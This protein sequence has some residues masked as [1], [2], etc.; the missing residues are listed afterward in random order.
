[1]NT[2]APNDATGSPAPQQ[3]WPRLGSYE[4]MGV[5]TCTEGGPK[6]WVRDLRGN[7]GEGTVLANGGPQRVG[8]VISISN[9]VLF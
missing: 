3:Q 2:P 5:M 7:R 8:E 6:E 1:M 4:G 9:I